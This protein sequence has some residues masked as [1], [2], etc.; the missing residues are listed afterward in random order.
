MFRFVHPDKDVRAAGGREVCLGSMQA[1]ALYPANSIFAQ[2]YLTTEGQGDA[3]DWS[4]IKE[5]GFEGVL[6]NS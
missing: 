5:A 1:L 6:V 4:M 3:K 2:G